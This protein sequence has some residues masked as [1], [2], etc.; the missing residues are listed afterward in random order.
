MLG[1]KKQSSLMARAMKSVSVFQRQGPATK[2]VVIDCFVAL[3]CSRHG[4]A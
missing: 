4:E 2:H 3:S 1:T